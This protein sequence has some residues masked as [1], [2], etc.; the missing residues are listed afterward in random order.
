MSQRINGYAVAPEAYKAKA[1][2]EDYFKT[3]AIEP[4]LMHLIKVRVSQINHCAYCLHMHREEALKDGD[5]EKRLLLLDA[6]RESGLFTP[7]ERAALAW[8]ESVTLIS[9][10]EAPDADYEAMR[11]EFN[12]KDA[13]DLT[14]LIAQI[15]GWNRIAVPLRQVHPQDRAR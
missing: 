2:L 9:T 3:T 13:V 15:N 12:E 10:T 11:F 6:W 5:T 1:A 4:S 8:A 7:R 14:F